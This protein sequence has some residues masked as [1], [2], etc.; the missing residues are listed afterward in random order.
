MSSRVIRAAPGDEEEFS[1]GEDDCKFRVGCMLHRE[2]D[3]GPKRFKPTAEL[4]IAGGKGMLT[5]HSYSKGER[6]GG[7]HGR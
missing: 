6:D 1:C 4:V 3:G 5:C 7:T 2:E